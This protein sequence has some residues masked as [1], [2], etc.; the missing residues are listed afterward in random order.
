MRKVKT[1]KLDIRNLVIITVIFFAFIIRLRNFNTS[2][3]DSHYFRQTQTATVARNYYTQGIDLLKS[4]LDLFG[5]GK[6]KTL[7]L[8]FPLYEGL[9]AFLAKFIGFTDQLGKSVSIFFGITGGIILLKLVNDVTKNRNIAVFSAIFYYFAP[10]NI[11]YQQAFMIESTVVTLN[12]LSLYLWNKYVTNH[13]PVW[14]YSATMI[15]TFAMIHKIIYAPFLVMSI[16][17]VLLSGKNTG[18]FH[19][20]KIFICILVIL[21]TSLSWQLYTDKINKQNNHEFY[22]LG[23]KD[24]QLWNF[25]TLKERLSLKSWNIRYLTILGSITK[26]TLF[27]SLVGLIRIIFYRKY[28]LII[29]WFFSM[30]VYYLVFFRI[31]SHLYYFMIAVPPISV[32]AAIGLDFMA[33]KVSDAA[34]F[35]ITKN[36]AYYGFVIIFLMIFCIKAWINS[37]PLFDILDMDIFYKIKMIN[38]QLQENGYV[39]YVQPQYGWN[40]VFTYYSGRKGILVSQEELSENNIDKL[41][42]QGYRYIAIIG[43]NSFDNEL[44]YIKD[45]LAVKHKILTDLKDLKIIKI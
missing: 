32:L 41:Y 30:V 10:L 18:L 14:L 40:S 12:I 3:I 20:K 36:A 8:E 1:I 25:G 9:V 26:F 28:Y 42:N 35:K 39:I 19:E 17:F 31:N 5:Q 34:R 24:Q 21:L 29:L 38:S 6:E 37:F 22:T 33:I 7:L 43:T 11:F 27:A 13:N 4:D 23:N 44:L 16:F 45:D 15:T 2:L